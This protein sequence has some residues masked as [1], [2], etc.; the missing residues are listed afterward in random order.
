MSTAGKIFK[1]LVLTPW[2]LLSIFTTAKYFGNPVIGS[3]TLN[4]LG[5]HVF[6]ILLAQGVYRTKQSFMVF[7]APAEERKR[8]ARDGYIVK[9]DFL[10]EDVFNALTRQVQDYEGPARDLVEG[11]T[12]TRRLFIS[13][14]E[15][16][17]F[18]A[19]RN[20]VESREFS[21]LIRYTSGKNE[22]PR[23]F[24]ECI[25][26]GARDRGDDPQKT[27][28]KD[29]FHPTVKAWLFLDDVGPHNGP[30]IY[31]PGSHKITW[32][33]LKWEYYQSVARSSKNSG[34]KSYSLGG[35][36][37]VD[38]GDAEDLRLPPPVSLAVRRNTLV[39]ADTMGFH[40]RGSGETGATRMAIWFSSR[41]NPFNPMPGINSTSLRRA[42]DK[43]YS[44]YIAH[45]DRKAEKNGP[46]AEAYTVHGR[47][48]GTGS[49][50]TI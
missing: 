48:R 30:F 38:R 22:I 45:I 13:D 29:T 40:R 27:L 3:K 37:R 2:W 1:N 14:I 15:Y 25:F 43:I 47:L 18:P 6:R 49:N 28:H 10:P 39:I 8:F 36:F 21:D 41:V 9:E 16:R 32:R 34:E 5:L 20:L 35:A 42:R 50:S 12:L 23:A 33:R 31:V 17:H 44:A 7:M 11:D 26:H 24:V 46:S 19:F 4:I